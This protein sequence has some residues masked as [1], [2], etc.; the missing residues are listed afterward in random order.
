MRFSAAVSA[1]QPV[2]AS[3]PLGLAGRL[4]TLPETLAPDPQPV[5]EQEPRQDLD[6]RVRELGEW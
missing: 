3:A 6:Q 1:A 5:P 2:H 4:S